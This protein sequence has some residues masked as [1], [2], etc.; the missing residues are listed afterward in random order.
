MIYGWF[1][2][3]FHQC[4]V[5]LEAN[6]GRVL[7]VRSTKTETLLTTPLAMVCMCGVYAMCSDSA[8]GRKLVHVCLYEC[9]AALDRTRLLSQPSWGH[10][11]PCACA[12]NHSSAER[13]PNMKRSLK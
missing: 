12:T 2:N 7:P 1:A 8:F 9:F 5:D 13:S 11:Y 4:R 6:R 3:C 10:K